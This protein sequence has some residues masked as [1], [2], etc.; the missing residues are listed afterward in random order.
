MMPLVY[1]Y[2]LHKGFERQFFTEHLI[3]EVAVTVLPVCVSIV[4]IP[5]HY[6]V[7]IYDM[8][9]SQNELNKKSYY[10]K[11]GLNNT[12]LWLKKVSNKLFLT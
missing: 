6:E 11:S 3:Q 10:N 1:L 7:W 5:M 4:Y 9:S 8:R 12:T 2:R